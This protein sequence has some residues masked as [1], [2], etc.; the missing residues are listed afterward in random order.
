MKINQYILSVTALLLVLTGLSM[1]GF[2]ASEEKGMTDM[3]SVEIA[4]IAGGCFWCVESDMEK[5]PGVIKAVSGYA[6]GVEENP[7]YEQVSGGGTS[8]RE[9]V[10]VYFDPAL[11][12]YEDVL[13]QYWKHFDP[14]DEGD[15]SVIADSSI[16]RPSSI[17]ANSSGRLP[18]L[19][20]RHWV[21][22]VASR[23]LW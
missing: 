8:H 11:V 9:A 4:T 10:Q 2:A 23:T 1:A 15:H 13:A 17:T 7:S 5:L 12:S 16:P 14:T 6:G 3:K 20:N 18:R 19:R 22:L 21:R